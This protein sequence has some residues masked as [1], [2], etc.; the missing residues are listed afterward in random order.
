MKP[1]F[2]TGG[3]TSPAGSPGTFTGGIPATLAPAIAREV[4]V[5]IVLDLLFYSCSQTPKH[6]PRFSPQTIGGVFSSTFHFPINLSSVN[7]FAAQFSPRMLPSS[8]NFPIRHFRQW[9]TDDAPWKMIGIRMIDQDQ[10]TVVIIT[11]VHLDEEYAIL[12]SLTLW[13]STW[14]SR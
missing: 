2:L 4:W 9:F 7:S 8:K 6:P 3:L 14:S 5:A 13:S 10:V 12:S 1:F 11:N